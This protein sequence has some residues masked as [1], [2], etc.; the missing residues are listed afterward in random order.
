MAAFLPQN[1]DGKIVLTL[2]FLTKKLRELDLAQPDQKRSVNS[3]KISLI[4]NQFACNRLCKFRSLGRDRESHALKTIEN[5]SRLHNVSAH[6][7]QLT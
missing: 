5:N 6:A 3:I 4:H 1:Y 7:R 2:L